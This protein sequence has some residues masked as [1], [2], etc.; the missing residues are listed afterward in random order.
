VQRAGAVSGSHPPVRRRDQEALR[1]VT[2]IWLERP[3]LEPERRVDREV[4][5]PG[6]GLALPGRDRAPLAVPEVVVLVRP[7]AFDRLDVVDRLVLVVVLVLV[8]HV[9]DGTRITSTRKW[10]LFAPMRTP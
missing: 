3:V 10:E 2:G 9:A 8:G 6:E 1:L 4:R 5:E 7:E